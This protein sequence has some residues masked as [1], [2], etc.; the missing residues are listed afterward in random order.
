VNPV[1]DKS[2][3]K[4][5]AKKQTA[6]EKRGQKRCQEPFSGPSITEAVLFLENDS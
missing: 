1:A 3:K 4:A 2:A 6:K 5:A